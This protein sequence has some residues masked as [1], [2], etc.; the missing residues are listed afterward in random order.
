VTVGY[1]FTKCARVR[2]NVKATVKNPMYK[3]DCD[4]FASYSYQFNSGM[5][6]KMTKMQ[7][8]DKNGEIG[9]S[10]TVT[11][12]H[13]TL[14]RPCILAQAKSHDVRVARRACH[15][16]CDKRDALY[17]QAAVTRAA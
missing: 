5:Q 16:K 3:F 12:R 11:S 13:D 15:D 17:V 1:F 8:F 7:A 10:Q 2:N 9:D 4:L 6:A 14:S